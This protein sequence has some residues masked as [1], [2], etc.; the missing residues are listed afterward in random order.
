MS[1]GGPGG[2][3]GT[4]AVLL[5]AGALVAL[6]LGAAVL[7]ALL[8]DEVQAVVFRTPLAIAVLVVGTVLV[9]WRVAIRRPP[10]A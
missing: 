7:T 5:V 3:R 6:V 4:R 10:A 2:P 1:A 9:L 8:P